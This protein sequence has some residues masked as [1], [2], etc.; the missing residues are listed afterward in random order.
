MCLKIALEHYKTNLYFKDTNIKQIIPV[1]DLSRKSGPK[2]FLIF[3]FQK[4]PSRA[5]FSTSEALKPENR[6][7]NRYKDLYPCMY[8][9]HLSCKMH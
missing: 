9:Y 6:A 8:M 2:L 4:L 3:V 1:S 5:Q 7:K